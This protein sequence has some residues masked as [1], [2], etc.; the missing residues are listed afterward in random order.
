MGSTSGDRALGHAEAVAERGITVSTRD[1]VEVGRRLER[2][3][4]TV[5]PAGAAPRVRDLLTPDGSGLSSDTVI[6]T[7]DHAVGG[8]PASHRLVVR[9]EP[10]PHELPVFPDSDLAAQARVMRLVRRVT[11]VPL[12]EA[13]LLERD[14]SVLGAPFLVMSHVDGRVPPDVLPYTFGFNWVSEAGIEERDRMERSAVRSLAGIHAVDPARHDLRFLEPD[15]PGATRLARHLAWWDR[16][17]ATVVGVLG[18]PLLEEGFRWLWANLPGPAA[19]GPDR[20]SWGDARIGN[21]L[22]RDHEVTAVLDWELAGVAPPEV[23][24]GWMAFMHLFF[25]DVATDLG[26]AGIPDFMRAERLVAI[27]AEAAGRVPADLT[28]FVVYAAVRFGAVMRRV[29]ERAVHFGEA[30]IPRDPDDMI[31]HRRLLARMLDGTWP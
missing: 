22:F 29:H 9:I 13:L 28:W 25:Q 19:V 20:L 15:T 12:P 2:W 27:Y 16:Y 17:R 3:F 23:D 14:R 24:L 31:L 7:L 1:P 6:L 10:S 11:P 21:M 26:M 4:R 8:A 30:H 5:L 18:S